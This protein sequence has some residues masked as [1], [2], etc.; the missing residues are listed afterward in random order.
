MF[1]RSWGRLPEIAAILMLLPVAAFAALNFTGAT[2]F[3]SRSGVKK[4]LRYAMPAIGLSGL[5]GIVVWAAG[6]FLT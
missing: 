4:E 3:T 1:G 6:R 5:A 2:P